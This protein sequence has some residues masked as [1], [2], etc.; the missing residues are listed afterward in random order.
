VSD[1]GDGASAS[2]DQ[3]MPWESA[4]R[5]APHWTDRALELLHA[6]S[7]RVDIAERQGIRTVVA[8]GSCP[9][10]GHDVRYVEV[11]DAAV[12]SPWWRKYATAPSDAPPMLDVDIR[13]ECEFSHP[14]KPDD[15]HGCG[16]IFAAR[17]TVT[18]V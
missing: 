4:D 11:L 14:G 1:D 2:G 8:K 7:L 9:R 5:T 10:C 13:C 17:T 3:P 18:V 16:I 12:H 6:G 15:E